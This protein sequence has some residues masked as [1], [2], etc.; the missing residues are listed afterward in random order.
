MPSFRQ[1]DRAKR[2][3][4]VETKRLVNEERETLIGRVLRALHLRRDQPEVATETATEAAARIAEPEP[5]ARANLIERVMA[6]LRGEP[7][8]AKAVTEGLEKVAADDQSL[9]GRVAKQTAELIRENRDLA[10]AVSDA[11]QG[12]TRPQ[13]RYQIEGDLERLQADYRAKFRSLAEELVAGRISHSEFR[14]QMGKQV[15]SLQTQAAILGAGGQ[16]NMTDTQR[17]LLDRSVRDQLAYLDGFHRDIRQLINA[18]KP[19]SGNT[20]SRAG[21]YAAAATVT[22]DQARRQSMAD[23]AAQDDPNLWEVRLL[24]IAEHCNDCV[25]YA[26][27]P[28][29]VGTLP[30]L[31]DSECGQHCKCRFEYGSREELEQK[32][33][34]G[35]S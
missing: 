2:V 8:P 28:A 30:P 29:P 3:E 7:D 11:A 27:R 15:K 31:G 33:G 17:R 34:R 26:N 13:Q 24:G 9:T 23:E 21:S 16:G 5:P 25:A 35:S 22:A 4:P 6:R 32:Y 19:L 20:V 10:Q 18:G 12:K 14:R 1:R